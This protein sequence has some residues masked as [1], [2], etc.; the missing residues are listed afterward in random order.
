MI[1]YDSGYSHL[2]LIWMC[3]GSLIPRATMFALPSFLMALAFRWTQ[4]HREEHFEV[5]AMLGQSAAWNAIS[6]S[7]AMLLSFRINNAYRRFWE[8]ITLVQQMRA[9]WFE[10]CSNLVAFSRV[11]LI[12]QGGDGPDYAQKKAVRL[13]QASNHSARICWTSVMPSQ[14]LR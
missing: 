1:Q 13:L 5:F 2:T 6:I 10:A 8:G 7:L 11:P 12:R 9:E 4:I 14:N 3:R